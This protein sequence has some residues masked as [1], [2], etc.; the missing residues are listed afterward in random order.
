MSIERKVGQMIQA[1]IA[2]VTPADVGQFGLGSVLNGGGSFPGGNKR[3]SVEDWLALAD[4]YYDA[5]VRKRGASP[6]R[7][8]AEGSSMRGA[9]PSRSPA[10]GSSMRGASPSRSPR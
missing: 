2:N 7:S 5:S 1:E 6:S 9:S 3:A 8:P 10:E 4:A